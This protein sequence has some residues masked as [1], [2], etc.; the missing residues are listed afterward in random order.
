MSMALLP[1]HYPVLIESQTSYMHKVFVS[2]ATRI[3][4]LT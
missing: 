1:F 2:E 3:I 4:S